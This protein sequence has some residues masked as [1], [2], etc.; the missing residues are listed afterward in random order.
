MSI[1]DGLATIAAATTALTQ[2]AL[3]QQ[4]SIELALAG[5]ATTTAR[6][7]ALNLVDNTADTDK[8]VSDAAQS[9]LNAKQATL[10]SGVNIKRVNGVDLTGSGDIVIVRSATSLNVVA[11]GD[12]GTLRLMSPEVDDST[13][14]EGLGLFMYVASKVEPDEDETCFTTALGQWLLRTP[15]PDVLEAWAF[16]DKSYSD[17]WREDEPK[18]FAAYLLSTQ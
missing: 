12:R 18:R 11:Y 3:A 13:V 2:V 7:N 10:V 9:E 5:F 8:P 15:A 4:A 1:E 14:V 6:V 17:D 16:W